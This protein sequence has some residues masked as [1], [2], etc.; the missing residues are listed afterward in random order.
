M[1]KFHR[2]AHGLSDKSY[3]ELVLSL[4]T[5]DG[6]RLGEKLNMLSSL[7]SSSPKTMSENHQ[8]QN[9]EP[10]C[11]QCEGISCVKL[12]KDLRILIRVDKMMQGNFERYI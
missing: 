1:E 4:L 12:A 3:E 2:L 6:Q 11:G 8:T 9:K 7:S 5:I 10:E